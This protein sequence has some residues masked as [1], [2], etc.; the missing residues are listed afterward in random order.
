VKLLFDE[1]L[2]PSLP[3]ALQDRYPGST[4]VHD[5]GLGESDDAVIWEYAKSRGFVIVTKDSD[6]E[7][8]SV[9]LGAPPKV[10]WLR[11]GNCTSRHLTSLLAAH[12]GRIEAFAGDEGDSLLVIA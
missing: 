2:P 11:T 12:A 1:N 5:C 8:K 7:Q 4:H 6:Y 9:L 10:I 3:A